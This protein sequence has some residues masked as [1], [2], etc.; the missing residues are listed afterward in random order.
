MSKIIPKLPLKQYADLLCRTIEKY[1]FPP[2]TYDFA[3]DPDYED[4]DN[5]DNQNPHKK[6]N[7]HAHDCMHAVEK[8]IGDLLL[9]E[10]TQS[11]KDGLS[12]VLYWGW[13]RKPGRRDDWVNKFRN[14]ELENK[15][16][17]FVQLAQE[18][19]KRPTSCE[20]LSGSELL[21]KISKL[22][23]P[24]FG[25][26]MPFVSKILMFLA[27]MNYPVLDTKIATAYENSFL[28]D[29]KLYGEGKDRRIEITGDNSKTYDKWACWCREIAKVV[30]GSPGSPCN[31]FRAVDVERALFTLA[32]RGI[33]RDAR[34]LLA[35]PEG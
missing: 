9:S 16:K 31:H 35:G 27:P 13:A 34:L 25:K 10:D 20:V 32:Q 17:E 12:N 30:N 23:L 8:Y 4:K 22:N 2:I 24:K 19:E 29:L 33:T 7:L 18:L 11:V 3:K 21:H 5:Q 28:G 15:I 1:D 6:D 26:G 14:A